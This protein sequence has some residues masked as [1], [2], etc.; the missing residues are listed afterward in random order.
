M[1]YYPA[2]VDQTGI[3]AVIAQKPKT[4]LLSYHYYKNKKELIINLISEGVDVFLDSGAFSAFNLNKTINIDN[5]CDFIKKTGVKHYAVLDV[6]G[7]AEATFKNVK[8]MEKIHQLNPLPV[9][10]MG[11]TIQELE[12]LLDYNYIALGG[13]VSSPNILNHCNKCWEIIYK[14]KEHLK[15]HGFGLTN[16]KML[17]RY[18]WY[19]VDSSSFQSGRRFGRQQVMD[20]NYEFTTISEDKF[21]DFLEKVYQ[22]DKNELLNDNKKRRYLTDFM[23]V[24]TMKLFISHL[25]NI[26][27]IKNFNYLSDQLNIFD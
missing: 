26:N 27:K 2:C 17:K 14:K 20:N 4:V 7:D 23:S 1:K 19:S 8:Y 16:I 10:H 21:L 3:D 22:Y 24:S 25:S 6:I 9:F 13:L 15:V 5:Y 12:R 18:P 11:G